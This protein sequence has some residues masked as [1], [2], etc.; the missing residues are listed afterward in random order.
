MNDL[1]SLKDMVQDAIDKGATTVEQV[2]QSIANQPL[3]ILEHV[4]PQLPGV[5]AVADV[6]KRTIGSVYNI[7]RMVNQAVGELAEGLL[8]KIEPPRKPE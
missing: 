3:E 5:K 1:K 4:A 8:K 6:Q 2:H 7:I